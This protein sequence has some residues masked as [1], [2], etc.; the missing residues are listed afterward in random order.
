M[1]SGHGA[2]GGRG[3]CYTLWQDFVACL[4]QH[5]SISLG[6]CKEQREDYMECLH[7]LKLVRLNG[8]Q[9]H[10]QPTLLLNEEEIKTSS[11]HRW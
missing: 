5:G 1:V 6:V 2:K 3:R 10:P 9:T 11:W 7:H 4:G 8:I